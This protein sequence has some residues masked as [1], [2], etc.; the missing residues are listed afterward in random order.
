MRIIR[1]IN[2]K[3]IVILATLLLITTYMHATIT[4]AFRI[5]PTIESSDSAGAQKDTF[6]IPE[7]VYVVGI[8]YP[9]NVGPHPHDLWVVEDVAT[10]TD[11][12]AIPSR[13]SGTA[14]SVSSDASGNI[15]ATLVW[16]GPLVPGKYDI[17]V[18]VDGDGKYDAG[19][20]ALDD[21]DVQV[22]AGFFV[23]PEVPLGT[24][25]ASAAMIIALV[26]YFAIPKFRK[27]QIS[28]NP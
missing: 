22:T 10:W 25:M 28:I 11:G 8:G 24:I 14:T 5:G 1:T 13:V 6:D 2:A 18:D 27:K 15:P 7:D 17:V 4:S 20:D 12:M 23:V 21:S 9:V 16:S 3:N 26:G 19:I